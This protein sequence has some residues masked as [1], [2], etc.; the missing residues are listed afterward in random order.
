MLLENFHEVRFKAGTFPRVF[1]ELDDGAGG[2][3]DPGG[4]KFSCADREERRVTGVMTSLSSEMHGH[5]IDVH[6]KGLGR[7]QGADGPR[8]SN[9]D[10]IGVHE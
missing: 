3:N 4:D 5:G 7:G 10:A 8:G 6:E 1:E 2:R 9:A